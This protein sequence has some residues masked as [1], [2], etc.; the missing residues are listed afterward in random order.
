[1]KV[2]LADI[3][4]APLVQ[5]ETELRTAGGTVLGVRMDASKRSD[6][7]RLT[8]QALDA[9]GQVDLLFNNAGVAAGGTPWEATW[10]DWSG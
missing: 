3:E 2:V 7:A 10:N 9:L 1:M 5:A 8:R 6:V 4:E